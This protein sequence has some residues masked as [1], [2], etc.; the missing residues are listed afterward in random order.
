MREKKK[1]LYHKNTYLSCYTKT[2]L[3]LEFFKNKKI[4]KEVK[5]LSWWWW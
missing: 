5:K 1:D 4:K 2:G 3:D